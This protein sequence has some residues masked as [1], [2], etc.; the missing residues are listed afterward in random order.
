M[1][2][3]PAYRLAGGT[4]GMDVGRADTNHPRRGKQDDAR[5]ATV[6]T[7]SEHVTLPIDRAIATGEREFRELADFAPV[8]IWRTGTDRL[9]DWFNKPWL[10]FTG[11]SMAQEVGEGWVEGIHPE[12]LDRCS[13]VF[14]H[15]F[16]AR[17]P[18]SLEYRLRR[19]DGVYR[20]IVENGMPF[21]R[22]GTFAGYW[23][24]CT[25][26]TDHRVAQRSQ[27]VLINEL[28]HRLKNT[29]SVV[30]AMAEQTF[31]E[32]RPM[33]AAVTCFAGRLR[34]L[35][36]AQDQLIATAWEEVPLADV[37]EATVLP[38]D[39]GGAR[40]QRQGP[41]L[42]LSAE[43]AVSLTMALHELL[44]NAVKYGALSNDTG[45]VSIAW[46]CTDPACG[47]LRLEW[48]EQGG[49]AVTTPLERGFGS[50]FIERGVGCGTE[51][52]STLRFEPDG[53]RWVLETALPA[54]S[55]HR[56][57]VA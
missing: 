34:A 32:G 4:T 20:W 26:I 50:R 15:A 14:F 43:T 29:L 19:H 38:F 21:E 1:V 55:V 36:A 53:V 33:G 7:M 46:S 9:G 35:A 23:G 56:A 16:D 28:S 8:M 45:T 41:P 39:C 40:I 57:Q 18:Y 37:V 12:D 30:Q 17:E 25:D 5:T 48:K 24:S 49:P 42:I 54:T 22:G 3:A 27:R 51:G 11:R 10:A 13:S 6:K 47:R 52:S 31:R 44:T 2:R